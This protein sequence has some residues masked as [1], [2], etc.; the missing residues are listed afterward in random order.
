[1]SDL[2]AAI[3]RHQVSAEEAAVL[4]AGLPIG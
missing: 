2:D 4:A 1:L 3:G